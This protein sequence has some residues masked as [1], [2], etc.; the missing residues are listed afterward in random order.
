MTWRRLQQ[1]LLT[2]STIVLPVTWLLSFRYYAGASVAT[3][4]FLLNASFYPGT[5]DLY[6]D[7]RADHA[8]VCEGEMTFD[9]YPAHARGPA[10]GRW[11]WD[12]FPI[13]QTGSRDYVLLYGGP[14][15]PFDMRNL[16]NYRYLLE[17]PLWVPWL[18]F[19]VVSLAVCRFMEKRSAGGKEKE[20]AAK[21]SA[22]R[23]P[24]RSS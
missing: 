2:G 1:C 23:F 9:S 21:D 16:M 10:P 6:L 12:H 3:R 17:M 19:T 8:S 5:L 7:L 24:D 11:M 18:L 14:D 4:P 20:L 13:R 15:P 22:N